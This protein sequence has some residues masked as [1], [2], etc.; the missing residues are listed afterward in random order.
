M[1]AIDNMPS[2]KE[3]SLKRKQEAAY[4]DLNKWKGTGLE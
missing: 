3:S 1:E 2:P 4:Q